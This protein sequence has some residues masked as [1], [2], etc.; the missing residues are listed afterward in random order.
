MPVADADLVAALLRRDRKAAAEFVERCSDALYGFVRIRLAPRHDLVED[1]VQDV[2]LQAWQ[3]LPRYRG[4]AAL[5]PWVI[6][7]ARHKVQDHYRGRLRS[8]ESP[9]DEP[10][11]EAPGEDAEALLVR[12]GEIERI[13]AT[14]GRMTEAYRIVLL[15]RYWEKLPAAGI[16]AATGRTE[17][18]VERL[19]ARA[20]AEFRR[21]YDAG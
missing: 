2:F 4:E 8:I 3:A 19:L 10:E 5:V 20:R 1:M 17:K 13:H 14:L 15:W 6:G 7:I 21:L 11:A 18:A 12:Q 16:A 9:W